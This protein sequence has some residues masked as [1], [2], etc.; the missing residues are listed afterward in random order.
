MTFVLKGD[1]EL[2]SGGVF[3]IRDDREVKRSVDPPEYCDYSEPGVSDVW[4][5]AHPARL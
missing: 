5:D 2:S 4:A 1:R 3:D